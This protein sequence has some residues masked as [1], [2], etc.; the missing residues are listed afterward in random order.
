MI[1]INPILEFDLNAFEK[2]KERIR[3]HNEMIHFFKLTRPENYVKKYNENECLFNNNNNNNNNNNDNNNNDECNLIQRQQKQNEPKHTVN[4]IYNHYHIYVEKCKKEQ[5]DKRN[6]LRKLNNYLEFLKNK[7]NY[8][9]NNN[10]ISNNLNNSNDK[11]KHIVEELNTVINEINNFNSEISE[12]INNDNSY[13]NNSN[14]NNNNNITSKSYLPYVDDIDDED[15]NFSHNLESDSDN[16]TDSENE[17]ENFNQIENDQNY[18][19]IL[20]D[21]LKEIDQGITLSNKRF[22]KISDMV[23]LKK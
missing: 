23:D 16:D 19:R 6:A 21:D 22:Q 20:L 5:D 1:K 14:E 18:V 7:N 11:V 17:N 9:N 15:Y 4:N 12:K 2:E 10:N 13:G 8:Y 3:K